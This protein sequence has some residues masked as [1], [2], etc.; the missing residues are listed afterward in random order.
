M[1]SV[2]IFRSI[3][4]LIHSLGVGEGG[5]TLEMSIFVMFRLVAHKVISE[6]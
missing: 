4:V 2:R 5:G 6:I 3:L 1:F